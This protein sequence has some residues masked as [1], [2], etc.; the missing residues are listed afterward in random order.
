MD[1]GVSKPDGTPGTPVPKK[2][3][4]KLSDMRPGELAHLFRDGPIGPVPDDGYVQ[5]DDFEPTLSMDEMMEAF[6]RGADF[7]SAPPP[8]VGAVAFAALENS[9]KLADRIKS[10]REMLRAE[11]VPT[12]PQIGEELTPRQS[13]IRYV[14]MWAEWLIADL[15]SGYYQEST[16]AQA[17]GIGAAL[18]FLAVFKSSTGTQG[19][20]RAGIATGDVL[21]T[22]VEPSIETLMKRFAAVA[23][24]EIREGLR[25]R[26]KKTRKN[27]K[28]LK[29]GQYDSED[30]AKYWRK[31]QAE[32]DRRKDAGGKL[33]WGELTAILKKVYGS[34]MPTKITYARFIRQW[35]AD[36]P[37]SA[38]TKRRP[39]RP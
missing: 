29:D 4:I 21:A 27:R 24:K 34:E 10:I 12:P 30:W 13:A 31:V 17:M 39:A 28:L 1:Q 7:F 14:D 9:E 20:G 32:I 22:T 19:D 37:G 15:G 23:K 3:L 6:R 16:V 26:D 35:H 33:K 8:A 36:H 38:F 11:Y 2:A 25:E 18:M 5:D